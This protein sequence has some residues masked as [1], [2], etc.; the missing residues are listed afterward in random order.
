M[1]RLSIPAFV[2]IVLV[3]A[4]AAIGASAPATFTPAGMA[5]VA[6]TGTAKGTSQVILVGHPDKTGTAVIRVKMPDG[7]VNQPHYHATAEY[8][9]VIQGALL[10]GTG[11][12]VDKATAT[13][14]PAGSFIEVPAGV[15][16]W[17]VTK[18]ITIEQVDGEAPLNN[19][20]IKHSM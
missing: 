16:H 2:T 7:Y 17:S 11:D 18:G 1:M 10:F 9:T 14:L 3:G 5:W 20:P 13:L 6:G 8:I 4:A 12:T 19:I 15:H